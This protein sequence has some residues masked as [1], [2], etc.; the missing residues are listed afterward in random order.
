MKVVSQI[1]GDVGRSST[2]AQASS[3]VKGETENASDDSLEAAVKGMS[4]PTN[5]FY[6]LVIPRVV[7]IWISTQVV[8]NANN[9][10]SLWTATW[11]VVSRGV[12][13]NFLGLTS[14]TMKRGACHNALI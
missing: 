7:K 14:V 2:T 3:A 5:T 8:C 1:R 11:Y 13:Y 9:Q 4:L 6:S 12:G 10:I